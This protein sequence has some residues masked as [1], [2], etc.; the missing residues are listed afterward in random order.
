MTQEQRRQGGL[1]AGVILIALGVLFLFDQMDLFHFPW[2]VA[3]WWPSL[4][5]LFGVLRLMSGTRRG[6]AGPFVLIAIGVILQGQML[7]WFWWWHMGRLWPLILIAVGAGILVKRL[8][9]DSL[10]TSGSATP[11]P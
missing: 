7:D 11:S 2:V 9:N 8:Q 5:I 6:W 1:W 4:L 3:R 10:P